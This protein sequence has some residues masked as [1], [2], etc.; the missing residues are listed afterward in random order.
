MSSPQ[1]CWGKKTPELGQGCTPDYR[2]HRQVFIFH[3]EGQ[4]TELAPTL[5]L[6][7]S[8]PWMATVQVFTGREESG[9]GFYEEAGVTTRASWNRRRE[10]IWGFSLLPCG[11]CPLVF[12][13]VT[14]GTGGHDPELPHTELWEGSEEQGLRVSSDTLPGSGHRQSACTQRAGLCRAVVPKPG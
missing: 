3:R 1:G 10:V 12:H 11:L 9:P 6:G 14:A 5:P 4:S 8:P 13:K 2:S 7:P